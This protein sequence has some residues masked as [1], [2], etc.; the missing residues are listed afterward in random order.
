MSTKSIADALVKT[1]GVRLSTTRINEAIFGPEQH[2][3]MKAHAYHVSQAVNHRTLAAH[4]ET[5]VNA[6]HQSTRHGLTPTDFGHA[7]PVVATD[8]HD[9]AYLKHHDASKHHGYTDNNETSGEH[10]NKAFVAS[11]E[12]HKH[13]LAAHKAHVVAA[14][15]HESEAG[16]HKQALLKHAL[17]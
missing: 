9:K 13:L 8:M 10:D 15:F 14:H 2:A 1:T 12:L 3:A 6:V 4:I 17:K 5:H 16:K 11:G 7:N